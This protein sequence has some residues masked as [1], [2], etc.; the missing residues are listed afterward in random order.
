MKVKNK[1]KIFLVIFKRKTPPLNIIRL[2]FLICCL[3]LIGFSSAQKQANIWH[4]GDGLCLDFSSGAP[5]IVAGSQMAATEGCASYCDKYGNFLFYTNG[6]GR[7]PA[8]SAQDPG[9]IWNRN[10]TVMYD[11][12]G[13]RGGGFSSAQSSVIFEAPGQ[14]S[15][16]YVFTMDELEYYVG[17]SPATQAA[18]PLGRGLSYFTVDMRLNGGLGGVVLADQ[19][20]Y[21]PSYEGICAI[22]HSNKRDYWVIINRDSTGLGVYSVTP[23]GVAFAGAYTAAGR[24]TSSTIK[25]SPNGALAVVTLSDL[26]GSGISAYVLS[27]DDNTGQFS[28]PVPLTGSNTISSYEF[29]PN[30]RYLYTTEA[31]LSSFPAVESIVRY[32]L[33]APSITASATSL[34]NISNGN[35]V[36]L[37]LAPDGKIYFLA[38]NYATGTNYINRI[39]CSNTT[40]SSLELDLFTTVSASSSFYLTFP[41]FPAWLFE[42]YDSV[43][44]SLGP[45]TV[46]LCDLGGSYVLNAQN[47]GSSYLWSTGATT[48]TIIVTS[49]GNYSVTVTGP[50]GIGRDTIVAVGCC[51]GEITNSSDSCLQGNVSFSITTDQTIT[52]VNWN[53]GDPSSGV[54]NTSVALTPTHNFSAAGTYTVTCIVNFACGVDTITKTLTIVDCAIPS[55]L[56]IRSAPDTCLQS[57][58]TFSISTNLFIEAFLGWNFGDPGSGGNNTSLLPA[59]THIFSDTGTYT[60]SCILQIN[61][62][63]TPSPDSIGTPCFYIDTVYKTIKITDCDTIPDECTLY[64]PT[65]FTPNGDGLNDKFSPITNCGLE[66][67]EI[68]IYNRWGEQVFRT[69][70]PSDKWD[71]K[72]KR[73]DC[74]AGAYAYLIKCRFPSQSGKMSKGTL[75]LLR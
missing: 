10:N 55:F 50:C 51:T 23:A 71:G 59:P 2:F 61:C 70:N 52:S 68:L 13:T 54:T 18:Q 49:P 48:Q 42:N 47:P 31:N 45:D 35:A 64:V 25:A 6:G 15:V 29:S 63:R 74:P 38:V 60:V 8:L 33:L 69:N 1:M 16:Y 5:V 73:S 24:S 3:F 40:T 20:V 17:A 12:L 72:Y 22:R 75:M 21:T 58:I 26:S 32:D 19:R 56:E 43:Y 9:H 28:N 39:N 4:F 11:M 44:V 62:V 14:D 57:T 41:N 37:Q 46:N 30:S 34:G 66:E 27:F 36:G 65:A 53:F 7:E 67:Y